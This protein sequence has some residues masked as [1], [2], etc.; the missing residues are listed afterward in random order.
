MELSALRDGVSPVAVDV[1]LMRLMRPMGSKLQHLH[2]NL[3]CKGLC[4][5][6]FSSYHPAPLRKKNGGIQCVCA[7]RLTP[8]QRLATG[9]DRYDLWVTLSV[10]EG[11]DG[12]LCLQEFRIAHAATSFCS[13]S[14]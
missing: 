7:L 13:H 8:P 2:P 1:A 5:S 4:A 11:Q 9:L 10:N 14:R 6:C 3:L 12:V